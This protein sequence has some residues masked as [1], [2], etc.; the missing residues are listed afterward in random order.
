MLFLDE[1]RENQSP[2]KHQA[3]ESHGEAATAENGRAADDPQQADHAK[4][5]V[6][7]S[8]EPSAGGPQVIRRRVGAE[9]GCCRRASSGKYGDDF[10]RLEIQEMSVCAENAGATED[11]A[12]DGGG[13]A[14]VADGDEL[15]A[16]GACASAKAQQ[17]AADAPERHVAQEVQSMASGMASDFGSPRRGVAV[18]AARPPE[19]IPLLPYRRR[20]RRRRR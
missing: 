5:P 15:I 10:A 6:L 11:A 12:N 9:I 20:R 14:A 18:A 4:H 19:I 8:R 3:F 17:T 13:A 7:A 2:T 1:S 16:Q